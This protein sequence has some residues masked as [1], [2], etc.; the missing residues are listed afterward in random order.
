MHFGT[1]Q[2]QGLSYQWHG[3]VGNVAQPFLNL[4]QKGQQP[5]CNRL[6]L[7]NGL[8]NHSQLRRVQGR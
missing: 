6:V 7:C 4:V 5:P 1:G 3:I 2:I 8:L